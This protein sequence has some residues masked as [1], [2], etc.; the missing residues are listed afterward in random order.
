MSVAV[1]IREL[2]E[3]LKD[4][5]VS[6]F[7]GQGGKPPRLSLQERQEVYELFGVLVVLIQTRTQPKI[8]QS[9]ANLR[10]RQ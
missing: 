1:A 5:E 2:V 10:G 8:L 4:R 7:G 9:Q 6:L 3:D